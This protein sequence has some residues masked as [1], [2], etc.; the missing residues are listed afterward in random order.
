STPSSVEEEDAR[1]W[2]VSDVRALDLPL[3]RIWDSYSGS[4]P[5]GQN[6]SM[7]ARAPRQR[8][9]TEESRR[10]SIA[11]HI[12]HS[13]WGGGTPFISF[14]VSVAAAKNLAKMRAHRGTRHLVVVDPQVRLKAG[15]PILDVAAEMSHYSI[16]DPYEK[17]Y[18]YYRDHYVCLWQ[19]A[20]D[21]VVGQ[22]SWDDHLAK[23]PN[24][25]QEIVMPAFREFRRK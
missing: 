9:D 7:M 1:P 8:L 12:V 11:H 15:L 5:D 23:Y 14:T 18:Q 10:D 24:W 13:N 6:N 2:S 19:A 4:Q 25:Y 20:G 16:R 17:G 21:E 3:L 22:W